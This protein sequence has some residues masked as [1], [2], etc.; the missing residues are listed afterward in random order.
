MSVL[1]GRVSDEI[2]LQLDPIQCRRVLEEHFDEY[3]ITSDVHRREMII[4]GKVKVDAGFFLA[5][6]M[7]NGQAHVVEFKLDPEDPETG[8]L[9]DTKP[10]RCEDVIAR[11]KEEY[12]SAVQAK[13]P[14][15]Q[16]KLL[17]L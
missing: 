6:P 13:T 5:F 17:L 10:V 4:R 16:R 14:N 9:I 7:M 1:I 11:T 3:Q 12:K 8:A 15:P 2:D